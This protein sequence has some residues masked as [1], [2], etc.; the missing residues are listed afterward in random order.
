MTSIMTEILIILHIKFIFNKNYY[1]NNFITLTSYLYHTY[2]ITKILAGLLLIKVFIQFK[3][4][5]D[6]ILSYQIIS[7]L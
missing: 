4:W 1:G 2:F 7:I 3:T 6:S 5:I